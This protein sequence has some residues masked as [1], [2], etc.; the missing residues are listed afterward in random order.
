M[1]G[2]SFV[3]C[4]ARQTAIRFPSWTRQGQSVPLV[5]GADD[6]QLPNESDLFYV[7]KADDVEVEVPQRAVPKFASFDHALVHFWF[8]AA[9]D[10]HDPNEVVCTHR[11]WVD[12]EDH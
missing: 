11:A 8:R 7:V 5:G 6:G 1:A 4:S 9:R 2:I 12:A 3:Y 10:S